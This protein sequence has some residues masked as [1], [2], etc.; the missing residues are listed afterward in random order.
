M[1]HSLLPVLFLMTIQSFSIFGCK[2]YNQSHFS[3]G[4]L[5]IPC[6]E[7]SLVLLE[8]DVCYAQCVLLEKFYY[9]LP[10]FI[11]YSK[12]KFACYS[13]CFLTSIFAF[14]SCIVKRT[15]FL[16]VSSKGFVGLHRTIQLQLLSITCWGI[17]L[18]YCDIEW[19]SLEMSRD[20]SVVFETASKYCI[21]DSC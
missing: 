9:P 11:L 2:E 14:Q 16:G 21:S 20:H 3:V 13:R 4:H 17:A 5:V 6:L 15:S 10:C 12:V 7:S 8:E 19:F 18:D 1:S